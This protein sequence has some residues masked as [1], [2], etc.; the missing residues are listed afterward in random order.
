MGKTEYDKKRIKKMFIQK[1]INSTSI[2][3]AIEMMPKKDRIDSKTISRWQEDDMLFKH[4]VNV[5]KKAR[6]VIYKFC[7]DMVKSNG[8]LHKCIEKYDVSA[9]QL[10]AWRRMYD[11]FD[12]M[13]NDISLGQSYINK[14]FGIKKIKDFASGKIKKVVTKGNIDPKTNKP[15]SINQTKISLEYEATKDVLN[16]A[17]NDINKNEN[18][19]IEE[20]QNDD[21][22]G[23]STLNDMLKKFNGIEDIKE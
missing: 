8:D 13:M 16:F 3:K 4:E 21:I 12:I 1:Y 22:N 11:W 10:G 14:D 17:E 15:K 6:Q 9:G 5:T 20:I 19:E 2:D 23:D 18:T 7:N